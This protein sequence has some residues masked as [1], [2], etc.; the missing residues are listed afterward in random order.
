M[1]PN[2]AEIAAVKAENIGAELHLLEHGDDAIVVKV[3]NRSQWR[4]FIAESSNKTPGA[5]SAAMENILAAVTV[6]PKSSA[7]MYDRR[8]A[9]VETFAGKVC[10]LAGLASEASAKK[11]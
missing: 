10:E 2:D 5:G 3:P 1:T 9:L 6:W 11:L 8:P 4:R 7:D